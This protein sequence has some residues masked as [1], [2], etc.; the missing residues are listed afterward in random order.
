MLKEK[1]AQ[2]GVTEVGNAKKRFEPPAYALD[3][4]ERQRIRDALEELTDDQEDAVWKSLTDEFPWAGAVMN[5]PY[6]N[7]GRVWWL[8]KHSKKLGLIGNEEVE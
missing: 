1:R 4:D 3:H 2:Y 6:D 5:L 8:Y 7:L